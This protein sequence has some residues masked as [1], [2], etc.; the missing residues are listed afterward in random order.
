MLKVETVWE[1]GMTPDRKKLLA[2]E[3]AGLG[4]HAMFLIKLTHFFCR[5][6]LILTCYTVISVHYLSMVSKLTISPLRITLWGYAHLCS[7]LL[8]LMLKLLHL[9]S[10][11]KNQQV[12]KA[13]KLQN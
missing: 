3:M 10:L 13:L 2:G 6:R 9:K 8:R 4:V 5:S 12:Q 7:K 11:D 1:P